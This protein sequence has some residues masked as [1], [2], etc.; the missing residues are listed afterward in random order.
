VPEAPQSTAWTAISGRGSTTGTATRIA[1]RP[2]PE[3]KTCSEPSQG[4]S[5]GSSPPRPRAAYGSDVS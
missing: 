4:S 3:A 5:Q 2:R 1:D